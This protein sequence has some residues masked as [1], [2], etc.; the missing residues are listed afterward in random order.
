MANFL[1]D[2][3]TCSIDLIAHAISH[4]LAILFALVTLLLN[5]LLLALTMLLLH[6]HVWHRTHA[7]DSRALAMVLWVVYTHLLSCFWMALYKR[8][9]RIFSSHLQY[10]QF[11]FTRLA[12]RVSTCLDNK[13]V[14]R[15]IVGWLTSSHMYSIRWPNIRNPMKFGFFWLSQ[16]MKWTVTTSRMAT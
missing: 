3:I 5:T 7:S 13:F 8:Q 1:I 10:N 12:L 15:F 4:V 2:K 9:L 11:M 16:C 14:D 6:S